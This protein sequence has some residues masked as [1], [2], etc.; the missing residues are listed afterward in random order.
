MAGF[1]F[2]KTFYISK[3]CINES[4]YIEMNKLKSLT[5]GLFALGLL[6]FISCSNNPKETETMPTDVKG[7]D[8]TRYNIN[9]PDEEVINMDSTRI[10][11]SDS[12]Q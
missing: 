11:S 8:P 1:S 2:F 10:D 6:L 3:G 9:A 7:S 5:T 12:V 4:K